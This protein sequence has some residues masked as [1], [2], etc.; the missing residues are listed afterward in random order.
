MPFAAQMR[1]ISPICAG[2]KAP[3]KDD[4]RARRKGQRRRIGDGELAAFLAAVIALVAEAQDVAVLAFGHEGRVVH[5]NAL[6]VAVK[7]GD[8][9][10]EIEALRDR[11]QR[12]AGIGR[13]AHGP[14]RVVQHAGEMFAIER[15]AEP[16]RAQEARQLFAHFRIVFVAAPDVAEN[17]RAQEPLGPDPRGAVFG[18][19]LVDVGFFEPDLAQ[20]AER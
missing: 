20:R 6:R 8:G 12:R 1:S 11:D 17:E 18:Q 16:T 10:D 2:G 5:R 19:E 3:G 7:V 14:H 13:L 15:R 4:R 9:D